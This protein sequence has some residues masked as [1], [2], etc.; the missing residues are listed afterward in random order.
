MFLA[1]LSVDGFELICL[2]GTRKPIS[3]Y[4]SC[5]WGKVPSD[6]V[7]VS[8]AVS[9]D[10]RIKYQKFLQLFADRYGK[11]NSTFN[12]N[13]R[14]NQLFANNKVQP[15]YD[16]FGNRVN[17]RF[18]R[19]NF[20]T[21]NT[22]V[23]YDNQ[24]PYNPYSGQNQDRS[25]NNPYG[26]YNGQNNFDQ[27]GKPIDNNNNYNNK[28][29]PYSNSNN[30]NPYSNSNNNNYNPYSNDAYRTTE[31]NNDPFARDPYNI[32]KDQYGVNIDPYVTDVKYNR[33]NDPSFG[34]N[35]PYDSNN[36]GGI[37]QNNGTNVTYYEEFHLFQSIPR[38]GWHGNLMFQ[39]IY[40]LFVIFIYH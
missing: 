22:R 23:T 20:D 14:N 2:D 32:N 9:A 35:N 8:S 31:P 3:D 33:E 21:S 34:N 28:N 36:R 37:N 13:T 4:L 15:E 1:Q 6:T 19:Q 27:N 5:N 39:V 10:D 12:S 25:R 18:K 11:P 16:Q 29:N 7:V 40:F 26:N 24:D 17:N 38:Y 30:S